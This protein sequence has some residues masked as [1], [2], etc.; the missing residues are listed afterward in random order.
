MKYFKPL[1]YLC[2]L[3][4]AVSIIF[5]TSSDHKIGYRQTGGL[6]SLH[7]SLT[8]A[9]WF[10]SSQKAQIVPGS[11]SFSHLCQSA[12][13]FTHF[14]CCWFFMLCTDSIMSSSRFMSLWNTRMMCVRQYY[15]G[16]RLVVVIFKLCNLLISIH[17]HSN[18][19]WTIQYRNMTTVLTREYLDARPDG[20]F[21]YAAKRIAQL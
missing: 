7:I 13:L 20:W 3:L 6:D 5:W 10:S 2:G 4:S 15:C 18:V 16:N 14:L 12:S 9:S 1:H 19:C 17:V 8:T 11:L 21:D